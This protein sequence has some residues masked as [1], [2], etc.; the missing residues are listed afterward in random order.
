MYFK[1]KYYLI[2]YGWINDRQQACY[3]RA[4]NVTMAQR[5]EIDVLLELH[6]LDIF[7][8]AFK[9]NRSSFDVVE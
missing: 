9:V 6:C 8:L 2:G 5:E 3:P 4:A 7:S 1:E